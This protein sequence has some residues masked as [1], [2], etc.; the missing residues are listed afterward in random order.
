[1]HQGS[2]TYC[3]PPSKINDASIFI[4]IIIDA[5]ETFKQTCVAIFC[6]KI[7]SESQLITT[8]QSCHLLTSGFASQLE[9]SYLLEDLLFQFFVIHNNNNEI[10]LFSKILGKPELHMVHMV[11]KLQLFGLSCTSDISS[12]NIST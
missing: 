4:I 2:S 3:R 9:Q 12:K 1:M 8:R 10:T 6:T 5:Q 11:S 7:A